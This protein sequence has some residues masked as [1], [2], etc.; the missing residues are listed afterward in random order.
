MHK[1]NS[2]V[3]S[4]AGHMSS[5]PAA[6]PW[7]CVLWEVQW[8]LSLGDRALCA[9]RWQ[10]L[11]PG[12]SSGGSARGA[13]GGWAVLRGPATVAESGKGCGVQLD[14]GKS[15][16]EANGHGG[17]GVPPASPPQPWLAVQPAI[18][19][20]EKGLLFT[21]TKKRLKSF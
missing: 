2:L 6:R 14:P 17:L 13:C 8:A 1:S 12:I 11:P 20:W 7:D 3:A 19:W 9:S 21:E 18:G 16:A 4:L 15:R 10:C 5:C